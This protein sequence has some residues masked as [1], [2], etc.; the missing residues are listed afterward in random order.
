M[1]KVTVSSRYKIVIP[2]E[3]RR[4]FHIRKGQTLS[5]INMGGAIELVPDKDIRE[6]RG[7][8]PLLTLDNIRD[9]K[10]RD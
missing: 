5:M 6:M 1:A 8:F 9:E 4:A 2:S 3:I 10:D 7:A